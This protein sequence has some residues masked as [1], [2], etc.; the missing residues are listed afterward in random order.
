MAQTLV[1]PGTVEEAKIRSPVA[2][3]LLNIPTLGI[4]RFFWWYYINNEMRNLG[5]SRGTDSLG[6]SPIASLFALMSGFIIVVPGIWTIVTTTRRVQRAQKMYSIPPMSGWIAGLL[7]ICTLGSATRSTC[8]PNS[9][10]SGGRSSS[11]PIA[12][13]PRANVRGSTQSPVAQ[14]PGTTHKPVRQ[15]SAIDPA[16]KPATRRDRSGTWVASDPT[17]TV[18]PDAIGKR[19]PAR[20][21]SRYRLRW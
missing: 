17:V 15:S 14:S 7:L 13:P 8:S 9:T 12:R 2:V 16:L 10:R 5:K 3:W 6:T 11:A 1:I 21:C 4:Y 18:G 20:P 19:S